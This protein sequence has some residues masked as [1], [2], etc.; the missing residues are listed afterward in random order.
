MQQ[1]DLLAIGDQ[2]IDQLGKAVCHPEPIPSTDGWRLK[3]PK[4]GHEKYHL[5][6]LPDKDFFAVSNHVQIANAF[7]T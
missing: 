3:R 7:W 2:A 1:F 6:P 4:R 5:S